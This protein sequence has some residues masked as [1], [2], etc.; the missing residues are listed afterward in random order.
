MC[1]VARSNVAP[2]PAVASFCSAMQNPALVASG[3]IVCAALDMR[4]ERS[5]DFPEGQEAGRVGRGVGIVKCIDNGLGNIC[6]WWE[7]DGD[8]T[9]WTRACPPECDVVKVQGFATSTSNT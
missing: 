4:V 2:K 7:E 6:V 8:Y 1:C 9:L 5:P 3:T